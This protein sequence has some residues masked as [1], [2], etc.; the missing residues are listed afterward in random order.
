MKQWE[1]LQN[2]SLEKYMKSKNPVGPF[3]HREHKSAKIVGKMVNDIIGGQRCLDVGC[4]LL[5]LPA[6]M[7]Q[8]PDVLW[9]G[10]DPYDIGDERQ[11]PFIKTMIEETPFADGGFENIFLGTSLDHFKYP[12]MATQEIKRI[13]APNGKLLIWTALFPESTITDWRQRGGAFNE[14]HLWGYSHNSLI[15]LFSEFEFKERRLVAAGE[16]FYVFMNKL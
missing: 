9:C 6:Y 5:P 12:T 11:F 3:S 1:D 13:L 4:G 14:T 8:S 7:E 2:E 15:D 10:I 16:Y